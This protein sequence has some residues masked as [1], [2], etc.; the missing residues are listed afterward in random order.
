MEA[1]AVGVAL[2]V[3]I[4]AIGIALARRRSLEEEGR[5]VV[6]DE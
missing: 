4:M 6:E 5:P 3:V 1:R 2:V